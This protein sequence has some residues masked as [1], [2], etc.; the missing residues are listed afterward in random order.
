MREI[1]A[2]SV[3]QRFGRA[4][5]LSMVG[6]AAVS[7][8]IC[9][10][11]AAAPSGAASV[12]RSER[13]VHLKHKGP[14]CS[15]F[16]SAQDIESTTGLATRMEGGDA[17][18]HTDSLWAPYHAQSFVGIPPD[19][20]C[21]WIDTDPPPGYGLD[22]TAWVMVGYGE[23]GTK[24]RELKAAYREDRSGYGIPQSEPSSG[25]YRT[26]KVGHGGQ[27]FVISVNLAAQGYDVSVPD[28]PTFLYF[29][30]VRSKHDNLLQVAFMNA[31]LGTTESLVDSFL[32][33][34]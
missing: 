22:N 2:W 11:A 29:V 32:K 9:A 6:A 4:V 15:S 3:G 25:P 19:S 5:R 16:F 24:W 30:T 10:A 17:F 21:E 20:Q 27:G 7:G 33:H 31:S 34:S 23:S 14:L 26:L 28:F 1:S 18:S 13:A 8:V 12:T